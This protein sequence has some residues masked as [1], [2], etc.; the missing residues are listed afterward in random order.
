MKSFLLFNILNVPLN[1]IKEFR[2]FVIQCYMNKFFCFRYMFN[3]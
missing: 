3:F 1:K 2:L